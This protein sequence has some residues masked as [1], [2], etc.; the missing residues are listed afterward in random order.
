MQVQPS[1]LAEPVLCAELM[2][3]TLCS[4]GSAARHARTR[5]GWLLM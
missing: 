2:Q 3:L 1:E 5:R 4:A